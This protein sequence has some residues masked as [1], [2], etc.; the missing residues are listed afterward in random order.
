M[1]RTVSILT[2]GGTIAHRSNKD[3]VAIMDF[4]PQRLSAEIGLPG[5]D[6]DFKAILQ[7]GSMDI[8]PGDWRRIALATADALSNK[9]DGIVILHGTDTMHYTA[10]ALSFMLQNAGVPIV[11]TGSMI[12]GGDPDS[13]APANLRDAIRVAAHS[14][15]AEVCIVFSADAERSK[16]VIIRGNRARKVHSSAV[17]AFRSIN[18][19]PIGFVGDEI[20]LSD[21]ETKRRCPAELKLATELDENVVLIKLNPAV[22]PDILRRQLH[23]ASA[24]V[25]EGTGVGHLNTVLHH[26]VREFKNPVVMSTQAADGGER[27]GTYDADKHILAIPN[28]IPAGDMTSE[29][30]LVKLMWALRQNEEIASIMQRNIVGETRGSAGG[31]HHG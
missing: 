1:R 12:P 9:P 15:V 10:A 19:L 20:A 26:T 27:L 7:K 24:A 11:L 6:L 22:T 21:L 8:V 17:D 25:L 18:A 28:M 5:I 13:D 2:T 31:W 4:D 23:G 16:S 29:T 30:A 14:D 3:G